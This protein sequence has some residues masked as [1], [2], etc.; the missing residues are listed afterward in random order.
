MVDGYTGSL[1]APTN[2]PV[3]GSVQAP[4]ETCG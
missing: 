3:R 4:V 2:R 1:P